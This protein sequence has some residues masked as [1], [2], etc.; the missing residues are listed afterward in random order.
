MRSQ[1]PPLSDR[2]RAV[3]LSR[4]TPVV[5]PKAAAALQAFLDAPRP[6]QQMPDQTKIETMIARLAMATKERQTT[7]EEAHERLDLYWRVLRNVPLT[8]L[9]A[10]FDD[11]LRTCTFMPTPAEVLKACEARTA[12]REFVVSRAKHLLWKH[13]TEWRPPVDADLVTRDELERIK[14]KVAAQLRA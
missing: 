4:E 10:A 14:A 5:G 12:R 9:R 11:L 6:P 7:L 8:D 1:E 2:L 13:H 3:I